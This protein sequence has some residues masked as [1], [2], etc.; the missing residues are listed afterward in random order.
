MAFL[1]IPAVQA[2]IAVLGVAATVEQGRQVSKSFKLQER[3]ERTAARDQEID[4][5]KRLLSTLA[6][7]N[8]AAAAGGIRA[9]EG[10]TL[11]IA[12][13]DL[14]TFKLAQS[15]ANASTQ[16]RLGTLSNQRRGSLLKTGGNTAAALNELGDR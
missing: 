6:S 9:F 16:V 4:R 11:N 5:R 14:R 15:T 12:R 3:K 13:E 1:T 10:S 2:G 8:V 7:Q